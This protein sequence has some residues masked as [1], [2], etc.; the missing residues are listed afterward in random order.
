MRPLSYSQISTYQ[1]CPLSYK[2]Q[3][4]DGLKPKAKWYFSFGDT[5]HKCAEYFYGAKLPTYPTLEEL[6]R[7]YEDNWNSEGWGSAEDEARQKVHGEQILRDFWNIH[8][9]DFKVPLATERMFVVDVAGVKL[10]GY[11]DRIDK[12]SAG[13]I[14]IVDY[15]S[16]QELF[17][18]GYVEN[19][20]QLTLYQLACEQMWDMP[21]QLLTLYHLRSNTP[22]SCGPRSRQQLD[23]ASRLVASVAENII[24]GKFPAVENQYCPCDFPEYCPYYKHKYGEVIPD[25]KRPE[26]LRNIDIAE[27]IERYAAIQDA[28]KTIEKEF[29]E[30]KEL[31]IQY[32]QVEGINRVFGP[33][34]SI[35]YKQVGRTGYDEE[36]VKSIL[37][38][39][40]LWSEVLKFDTTKLAAIL[41][42]AD[43]PAEIKE[44]ITSLAKVVS[45]FPR[46]WL[47]G[48]KEDR[49]G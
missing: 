44:R 33:Q 17:I 40:G 5:L 4:V 21:V 46:L 32:C 15:K 9:H 12:L 8:S 38:P 18:K 10:R 29:N 11:I 3:Y 39:A 35:T 25:H 7:F 42:S 26:Q 49:D 34:H 24:A 36:K 19:F 27:V 6:L 43:V 20:F 14:A 22:I 48:L 30:L 41:E 47:K 1:S 2:L 31:I 28:Q 45:I 16:N 13:G 23:T 37:E